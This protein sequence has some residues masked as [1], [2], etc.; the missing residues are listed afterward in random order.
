[1]K[2]TKTIITAEEFYEIAPKLGHCELVKGEIIEMAPPG[3]V[4]GEITMTIGT[5]LFNHVKTNKLG[6]VFAAETGF[7]VEPATDG[8]PRDTVRGP[9]VAYVN[10]TRIPEEGFD[11][12]WGNF[13]PDLAVEVVS[14]NDRE[15]Q[16]LE[17]VGEY[18]DA[19][20]R[21]VWVI[22]PKNKTVTIYRPNGEVEL[23][24][25]DDTLNGEE[26]VQGFSCPVS[27]IFE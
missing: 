12:T 26:V 10:Q 21:L 22:R 27:D 1:V 6:K 7:I 11:D 4:H 5:Q 15:K 24:H 20:V 19:G 2:G 25:T 13:P 18:L 9:D 16:V 23:L 14:K 8:D 17:K 3:L